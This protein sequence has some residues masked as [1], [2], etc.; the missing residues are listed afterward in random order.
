[1]IYNIHVIFMDYVICFCF[2]IWDGVDDDCGG[3]GGGGGG[4]DRDDD[5]YGGNL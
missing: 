4:G 2:V 3:G 1:M 5:G